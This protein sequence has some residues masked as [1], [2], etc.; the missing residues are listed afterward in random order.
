MLEAM[1]RRVSRWWTVSSAL[2]FSGGPG[3]EI[4]GCFEGRRTDGRCNN[5]ESLQ[6]GP[7]ENEEA[8]PFHLDSCA[9]PTAMSTFLA[10]TFVTM[11]SITLKC[12]DGM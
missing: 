7:K 2:A 6:E 4:H 12:G 9:L 10:M 5:D 8:E 3:P 1:G 11:K